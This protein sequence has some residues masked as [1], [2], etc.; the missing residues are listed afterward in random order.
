MERNAKGRE[1]MG[2][3]KMRGQAANDENYTVYEA[4]D[5]KE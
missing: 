1:P 5:G 4:K 2:D 3:W